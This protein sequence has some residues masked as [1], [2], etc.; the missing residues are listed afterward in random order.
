MI[1]V[2]PETI[3]KRIQ[4]GWSRERA[5]STPARDRCE[6][7][8]EKRL[9]RRTLRDLA[10]THVTSIYAARLALWANWRGP[11]SHEPL[12]WSL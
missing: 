4:R 9:E 10:C 3:R 7:A 2:N 1:A 6:V 11:V 5:I 12:R 8:V